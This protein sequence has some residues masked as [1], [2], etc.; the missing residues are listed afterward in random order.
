MLEAVRARTTSSRARWAAAAYAA[1]IAGAALLFLL[2]RAYGSELSAPP[3]MAPTPTGPATPGPAPDALAHL[4]IALTAI[5]I[6]GRVLRQAFQ[7]IGQPPV[8]GEVVAGVLLG[9]SLLG[10]ISPTAYEFVLAP[11]VAPYLGIVAQL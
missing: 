10:A 6:V 7:A 4:L 11:S 5:V 3:P 2:I 1:T 8:I 9:P